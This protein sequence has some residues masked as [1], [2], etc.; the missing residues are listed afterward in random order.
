M[1]GL[2]FFCPFGVMGVF[3]YAESF[4]RQVRV[5]ISLERLGVRCPETGV[6]VHSEARAGVAPGMYVIS[7]RQPR[8]W[9]TGPNPS[10]K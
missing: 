3:Y 8:L 1:P 10:H 4:I 5:Y 2:L 9:A 6:H 7:R